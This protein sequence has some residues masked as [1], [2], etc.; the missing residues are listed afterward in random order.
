VGAEFTLKENCI[1][2]EVGFSVSCPG[3]KGIGGKLPETPFC[4]HFVMQATL[5]SGGITSGIADIR[6]DAQSHPVCPGESG[7]T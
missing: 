6:R 3:L 4:R 1:A 2:R 5:R 7:S